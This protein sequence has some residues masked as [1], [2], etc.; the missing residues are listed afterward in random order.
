MKRVTL[1]AVVFL[2]GCGSLPKPGPQAALY[3]FGFV[4][5]AV[6]ERSKVRLTAVEAASGLAGDEMRYRLGYQDPARVFWYT[7]SR[8]AASP[9]KLLMRRFSQRLP[10][11]GSARCALQLVV[12][13]FDQVFDT[14]Q[15]SRGVVRL[16][17][18]LLGGGKP[19]APL[20]FLASADSATPTADARGGVAALTAAADA[21]FGQALAWAGTQP[22]C[23]AAPAAD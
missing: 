19:G 3:D 17:A 16:Q 4:P 18:R 9:A 2:A 10:Q 13:T 1:I 22:S 14:P 12:E 23:Q 20:T 6:A 15:Q 11:D 7:E 21:A 5:A 8:W